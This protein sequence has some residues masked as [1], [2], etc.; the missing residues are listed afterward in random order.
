VK[1]GRSKDLRRGVLGMVAAAAL[2]APVAVWAGSTVRG[3]VFRAIE[4]GDLPWARAIIS[5][6]PQAVRRP[7][8]RGETPLHWAAQMGRLKLAVLLVRR[9]ARVDARNKYRQQPIHMAVWSPAVL[10]F[11]LAKGADPN[12]RDMD[13]LTP[14]H[15][16]AWLGRAASAKIL[17]KRGARPDLKDAAGRTPLDLARQN[18]HQEVIKLLVRPAPASR[19]PGPGRTP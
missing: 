3:D 15:W 13:R 2:A 12:A 16:A 10:V 14:L 11:L 1:P 18:G 7:D 4:D 9:G 6:D 8:G 19:R 5:A 17:L